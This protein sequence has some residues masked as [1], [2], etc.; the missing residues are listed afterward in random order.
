M[1]DFPEHL[2]NHDTLILVWAYCHRVPLN[3][4]KVLGHSRLIPY[5]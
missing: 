3:Y 1:G 4:M 2:S 5:P